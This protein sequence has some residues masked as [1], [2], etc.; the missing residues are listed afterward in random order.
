[1]D[2]LVRL[3]R[4]E[5]IQRHTMYNARKIDDWRIARDAWNE[6]YTAWLNLRNYLR[7]QEARNASASEAEYPENHY[8][9]PLAG[10]TDTA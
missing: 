4:L 6:T 10:Q 7:N 3:D 5:T 2:E 9:E 8:T 1:M